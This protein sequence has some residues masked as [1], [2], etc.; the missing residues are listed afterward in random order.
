MENDYQ[1]KINKE[2]MEKID[3]LKET[4]SHIEIAIAQLPEK[5]FEKADK[6]YA[7]KLSE[8]IIYGM[9]GTI[10]TSVLLAFIYTVI[11]K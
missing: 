1:L 9:V 7:S 4:V 6:R 2:I 11:I 3:D 8:K 5:L 10:I